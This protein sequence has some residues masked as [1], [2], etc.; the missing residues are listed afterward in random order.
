MDQKYYKIWY[1][2]NKDN[3]NEYCR[4]RIVC[5]CGKIISRNSKTQHLKSKIHQ[6]KLDKKQMEHTM[7]KEIMNIIIK[8]C[9][10]NKPVIE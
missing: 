7:E 10:E 3:H 6:T 5:E 4:Q 8:W 9:E 1:D 2:K